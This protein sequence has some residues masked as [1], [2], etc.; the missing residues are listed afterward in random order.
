MLRERNLFPQRGLTSTLSGIFSQNATG[1][2][3][4]CGAG[5]LAC[6]ARSY[7]LIASSSQTLT[8]T[9]NVMKPIASACPIL[10]TLGSMGSAIMC[11]PC[12]TEGISLPYNP[13]CYP[14]YCRAGMFVWNAT[15]A[16]GWRCAAG[17]GRA[18]FVVPPARTAGS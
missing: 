15:V 17:G 2:L 7:S 8:I 12:L 18:D 1:A 10:E 16:L 13:G 11:L 3:A 6:A 14:E 9:K 5:S 4:R